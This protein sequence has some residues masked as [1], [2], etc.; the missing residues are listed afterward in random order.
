MDLSGLGVFGLA[1]G[2]NVVKG[3][4]T[5]GLMVKGWRPASGCVSLGL[6]IRRDYCTVAHVGG[7]SREGLA[8]LPNLHSAS[9]R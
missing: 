7:S 1:D 4:G 3:R 2:I 9:R 5:I 8:A 6:H